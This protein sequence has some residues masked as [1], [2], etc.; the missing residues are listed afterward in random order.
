MVAEKKKVLMYYTFKNKIGGPLVYLQSI[1]HSELTDEFEFVTCFQNETAGGINIGLLWRMVKEIKAQS[2]DIVHVHG[3]Q[4][5]GFYGVLAAKLAG[6]PCVVMTVHGLACDGQKSHGAKWFLY[7]YFV[8]PLALRLSDKVYCVCKYASER[9]IIKRN[10]K[11]NNYGYIHNA[12]SALAVEQTRE[13][14]RT[15]WKIEPEETV[16]VIAGRVT[17]DKGFDILSQAV[18][19]LECSDSGKFRLMVV[20]NGEYLETFCADMHD[21]IEAG[22]VIIIGQ[23]NHVAD[24]L[25]AADVFVLPS[26][27]ENLP[28]ALLEAGKMG[29]PCVASNVGGVSEMIREGE[30]GFLIEDQVP[31]AYVEKMELL[32][33]NSL[34]RY[35]MSRAIKEDVDD[36][37]S[38]AFMCKRI[39]AIYT[40]VIC[41]SELA[42]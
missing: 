28:I 21:E 32:M 2:P 33:T 25:G 6:C 37:F 15:Q 4:S 27:H 34:L 30:T 26:Y 20:G 22:R 41:K 42:R 3:V 8:E 29:L 23:T 31:D 9:S 12:V 39:K 18:K 13:Q 40:D 10:T 35:R 19:Q 7:R 38:M 11:K 36:R 5:E 16:F 17:R 1:I 24:Y 14:V